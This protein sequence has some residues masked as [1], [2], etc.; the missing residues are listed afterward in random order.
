M[1]AIISRP[2][3]EEVS[4]ILGKI[5]SIKQRRNIPIVLGMLVGCSTVF[6]CCTVGGGSFRALDGKV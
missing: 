4:E 6:G 5:Y 1:Y 3:F 2:T